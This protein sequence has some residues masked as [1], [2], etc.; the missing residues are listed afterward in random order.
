[1]TLAAPASDYAFSQRHLLGIEGLSAADI[2]SLLDLAEEEAQFNRQVAKKRDVLR[3]RTQINLFFEA[4]TRT[5]SSF[6]LAGKRLGA[7]VMNMA[8]SS[9][10]IKKGETVLDTAMTLNAMRPDILVVRHY[11]AGAVELLAQKVDCSVINAGDGSHEHPTQ[12]LLDALTIRRNKGRV[13]GLIVAICG[14]V[15]HSRVARSNIILFNAL[16]AHVRIVAPSTLLP[17]C[18]ERLGVEVFNSMEEG[19]ADADIVMMLRLQRERMSGSF[20]PSVREYFHFF[21]LDHEKLRYAKPDAMIMHPGPM[22]R[23]VEIDSAVADDQRSLISEQ[24]EMGV[25][26]RMAAMDLLARNQRARNDR[27]GDPAAA[28]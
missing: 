24:V 3:G 20:V 28:C 14:D 26:V 9:S 13:Q 5:Q 21:G 12:A 22:N 2:L 15:L 19:I 1:M 16:G 4:S 17:P 27:A 25:A 8:V 23:G 11:A 6:E 10:S 7:D 18:A